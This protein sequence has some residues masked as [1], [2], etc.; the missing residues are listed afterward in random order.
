MGLHLLGT[1]NVPWVPVIGPFLFSVFTNELDAGTECTLGKF[2]NDTELGGAVYPLKACKALQRQ[3]NKW[4]S[5]SSSQLLYSGW[6]I[7]NHL[8]SRQFRDSA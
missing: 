5:L 2:A 1:S 3:L 8:V 4:S 7:S 6:L